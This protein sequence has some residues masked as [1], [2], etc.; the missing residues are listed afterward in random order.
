MQS[1]AALISIHPVYV[2]KI[3]SG[4]KRFEFRRSWATAPVE[5]LVIYATAPVQRIVAIAKIGR[6]IRASKSRLWAVA[7]ES[8]PGIT[9]DKLFTYLYGKDEGVALELVQR[10]IINEQIDPR[11]IFG[12]EFSPP[13]SFRYLKDKEMALLA[14]HLRNQSW[15]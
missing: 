9:R 2:D 10:I 3:L 13:Q 12:K 14:K 15:E 6:T 5:F 4:E 11:K 8:G 1:N 7:R